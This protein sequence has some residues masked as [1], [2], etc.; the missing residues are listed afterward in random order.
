MLVLD[1]R[2]NT[3]T[4]APSRISDSERSAIAI[5]RHALHNCLIDGLP[6]DS[7]LLETSIQSFTPAAQGVVV[8]LSN[9]STAH[10]SLLVGADGLRSDIRQRMF[11]NIQTRYSGYTCWR[12]ICNSSPT[13]KNVAVEMLGR[14]RRLGIV[15]IGQNQTYVFATLNTT[16]Q[17]HLSRRTNQ[18]LQDVMR[19]FADFGGDAPRILGS[20]HPQTKLIHNDL[21][22]VVLDEWTRDR[23]VLIGDAAHGMTPNLG[24]GAAM[25][26]E[27]A[28][29][30]ARVW[31][32][33]PRPESLKTYERL[34]RPRVRWIQ[35]SSRA[36]GKFA[37]VENAVACW[38]RDMTFKLT[39]TSVMRRNV[40]KIIAHVP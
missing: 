14:G 13:Q 32:D 39:P 17:A 30:L 35:D 2:G 38:I 23:I 20:I 10:Y 9:G 33:A 11:P 7:M 5:H 25:G 15:P 26:I 6:K 29:V 31:A 37:Q 3:L 16:M 24:Q 1:Q 18:S 12:T 40:A 21:E 4:E 28:V 36:L 19:L 8:T 27:D 34:R 22:E